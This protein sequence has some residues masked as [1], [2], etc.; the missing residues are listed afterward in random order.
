MLE[1]MLK[2]RALGYPA[3]YLVRSQHNRVL[4]GGGKLWDQVMAQTPLGRIR[5]MLPAGRGRK[6]AASNKTSACSAS[7]SGAMPRAVSK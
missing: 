7:A 4:P 2:A 1:L 5:F 6:V 3:D